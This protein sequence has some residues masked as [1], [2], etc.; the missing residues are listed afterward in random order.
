MVARYALIRKA[1]PTQGW[2]T[3]NDSGGHPPSRLV[4]PTRLPGLAHVLLSAGRLT[5]VRPSNPIGVGR[6]ACRASRK[7]D[8]LTESEWR[9]VAASSKPVRS[10]CKN[11]VEAVCALV[12]VCIANPCRS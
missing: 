7:R 11:A 6:G 3:T 9:F 12:R 2:M 1:D 10:P 4:W 5:D 8:F